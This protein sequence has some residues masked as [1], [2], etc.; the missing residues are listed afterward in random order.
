VKFSGVVATRD[1]PDDLRRCLSAIAA[2]HYSDFEVIVADQSSAADQ[3]DIAGLFP[4]LNL[5]HLRLNTTGKARGLNAGLAVAS[6]DVIALTDD[7]CLAPTG[8]LNTG[9]RVLRS[10]PEAGILFGALSAAP[11]DASTTYIPVFE[12]RTFRVVRGRFRRA[13]R[14]GVGAN[15]FIRKGVI[16]RLGAFDE[17]HGPGGAFRS[18]DD[19]EFA[20][21]ALTMGFAVIQDPNNVVIHHGARDYAS[22]APRRLISNN[23]HGI[24][25]GYAHHLRDGDI[26]AGYLL[27]Q[28]TAIVMA[29][30]S[31]GFLRL[32][33]PFGFRR[34]Q[35]M[36]AGALTGL[37]STRESGRPGA[38]PDTDALASATRANTSEVS[39]DR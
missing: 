26:R 10:H 5:T 29:D 12:P 34:L 37:R 1:R 13:H 6:G 18:G 39:P 27:L 30:V 15:M 17:R 9:A 33:R 7:D 8:W 21:R 4:R 2:L 16:E 23:Y 25:A 14:L 28:E 32:R 11:H 20:Y 22:G 35:S 24:G 31:W 38:L 36:L 3:L 19:W